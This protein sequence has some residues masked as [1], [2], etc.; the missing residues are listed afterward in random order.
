MNKGRKCPK[1]LLVANVAKEHVLKFHIPTIKQLSEA[2]WQIDV[3]CSGEESVP[4]CNRQFI[5]SYK[6]SPFN[7]AL[8]KGI[9]ELRKIVDAGKYD[10][11]YCHTPVGGMAAR[12]ASI[13]ARK[14]GTK[15]VYFAHGFHFFKGAPLLNW[16][17]YYP[18]EKLLSLVTDSIILINQE[19]Y[20]LTKKKFRN[21]NA[22]LLNGIG[23]D[24]ERFVVENKNQI[25]Q[26]YRE[27][28]NVPQDATVLIYLAELL[29]NKNQSF[30]MRVLKNILDTGQ[31]VY[32]VLAGFD[33]TEGKFEKYAEKL[34]VREHVRFVGWR[35][36]V[37]NLYAMSDICT[38]TSIREG[39]GLNLVEA[40]ICG[41]P[42]VATNNRGHATIIRNGENGFLIPLNEEKLFAKQIQRLIEDEKLR[43][44]YIQK[45]LQEK[46]K[47]TSKEILENIMAILKENAGGD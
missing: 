20:Q 30:L 16:M 15:V 22:Y 36:D 28:F 1:V 18:I 8:F 45:G 6:R 39:F 5:M 25:R 11:V 2:G 7:F 43:D 19:D 29:P 34:G 35:E 23:V 41:L 9:L 31:N 47:Y 4:Y 10:I 46:D 40:M 33:H 24:E 12:I 37:G 13:S 14:K 26:E 38:A 3:A 21:C 27:A 44:E 42:V 32:L 17:L